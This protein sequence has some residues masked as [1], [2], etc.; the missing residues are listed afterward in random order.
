MKIF[1]IQKQ[2]EIVEI[3]DIVTED[4]QYVFTNGIGKISEPM[5]R[6][7]FEALDFNQTTGYLP[8]ACQIPMAGME[9]VH[10]TAMELGSR[11][12]FQVRRSQ[13]KF[14]CELSDLEV[15][16]YSKPCNLTLNRQVINQISSLGIEDIAFIHWQNESRLCSTMALLKCREAITLLDNVRFYDL[17]QMNDAW[18][19]SFLVAYRRWS[20]FF[21]V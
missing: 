2:T 6:C 16:D 12:V 13:I 1:T 15:I 17:E 11:E 10:C 4:G 14:E 20:K 19:E 9:G 3:P 8:C 7:V 21:F 18:S 5:M